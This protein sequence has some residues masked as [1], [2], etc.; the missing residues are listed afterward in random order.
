MNILNVNLARSVWL[1]RTSF[2]NPDG[3]SVVPLLGA[4]MDRYS[5][6]NATPFDQVLKKN[7]GESLKY[8]YGTFINSQQIPLEI[9]LTIHNDGLVVDTTSST[10]NADMFLEDILTWLHEEHGLVHPD[11]LPF[12]KLHIS[13][14]YFHLN[15]P[16]TFLDE[17]LNEFIKKA[18]NSIKNEKLGKFEFTGFAISTD[19]DNSQNVLSVRVEREV[20]TS[21]AE[22]R[23]FSSAQLTSK[24]H[25]ALLELLEEGNN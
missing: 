13:E 9:S 23:F 25:L 10:E 2:L 17:K 18:S 14:V 12:K 16:T 15:K 22:N 8:E 19:P 4:I 1:V 5:F 21:F 24:Q 20:N 11:E 3:R 6:V 7:S